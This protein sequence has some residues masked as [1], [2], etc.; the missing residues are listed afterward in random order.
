[1]V[2]NYEQK[3]I[4]RENAKLS[5]KQIEQIIINLFYGWRVTPLAD[6]MNVPVKTVRENYSHFLDRLFSSFEVLDAF[7]S[8]MDGIAAK[9]PSDLPF[10]ALCAL[11]KNLSVKLEKKNDWNDDFWCFYECGTALRPTEAKQSLDL[12][13]DFL[14]QSRSKRIEENNRVVLKPSK[15]LKRLSE[16]A[17]QALRRRSLHQANTNRRLEQMKNRLRMTGY[18]SECKSVI[19][20]GI[21][22]RRILYRFFNMLSHYRRLADNTRRNKI[23]RS[24]MLSVVLRE[25]LL[26]LRTAFGEPLITNE[27]GLKFNHS[28]T[29]L[30][31]NRA[32]LERVLGE[33]AYRVLHQNRNTAE[34]FQLLGRRQ[35]S[36]VK[37]SFT[38]YH[39][40]LTEASKWTPNDWGMWG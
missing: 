28:P 17:Q 35:L 7:C 13:T 37:L 30:A 29:I 20:S 16:E 36:E 9:L 19:A 31:S 2:R 34:D 40:R 10:M 33:I 1:M 38:N 3:S 5:D 4:W 26:M 11:F 6:H 23:V 12:K 18:C 14:W 8:S 25:Y 21:E 24:A 22:D 39:D 15:K 32:A 27:G